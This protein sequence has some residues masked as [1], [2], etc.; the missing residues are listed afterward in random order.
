MFDIR[1]KPKMV[2]RALLVGVH[3]KG[4]DRA[5][6]D[7]LLIEL[8]ELVDTLGIPVMEQ[9]LVTCP[10]PHARMLV[11]TGKADEI[12][13][14]AKQLDADVIIIDNDLSPAQ[15]RTWEKVSGVCVIDREEVIL[16]IFAGRAFTKEARLQVELA[17]MEY[18]LPRLT[19]AWTHLSRQ[20]GSGGT[21]LRGEGEKQL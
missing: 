21:G 6:A 2:E 10:K 9:M 4:G 15:Q 1:D 20:S 12:I 11:G 17:R 18:S 13:E 5:E 16:D 19:R 3:F 7:S 8:N 14:H